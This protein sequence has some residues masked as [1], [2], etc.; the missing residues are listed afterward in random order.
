MILIADSGSTKC[1]WAECSSNGEV[2][3]IHKTVGFN[4][5]YTSDESLLRELTNSTLN[6]IKKNLLHHLIE[7]TLNRFP[8]FSHQD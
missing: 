5:K 6:N 2:I 4:P 8:P 7:H 1:S 3:R